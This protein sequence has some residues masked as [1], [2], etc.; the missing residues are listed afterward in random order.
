MKSLTCVSSYALHTVCIF[1]IALVTGCVDLYN[2]V[3]VRTHEAVGTTEVAILPPIYFEEH[4]RSLKPSFGLNSKTAF[5]Q[6]ITTGALTRDARFRGSALGL[7]A[8]NALSN[9]ETEVVEDIPTGPTVENILEGGSSSENT[10]NADGV[11]TILKSSESSTTTTTD[12]AGNIKTTTTTKPVELQQAQLMELSSVQRAAGLVPGSVFADES[13]EVDPMLRYLAATALYQE[14]QMLERYIDSVSFDGDYTPYVVRILIDNNPHARAMPYDTSVKIRFETPG[15]GGGLKGGVAESQRSTLLDASSSIY[16]VFAELRTNNKIRVSA[17]DKLN[18]AIT[19]AQSVIV[20]LKS[21]QFSHPNMKLDRLEKL[22]GEA[23]TKFPQV[24]ND[25]PATLKNDLLSLLFELQKEAKAV[26]DRIPTGQKPIVVPML[27]TDALEASMRSGATNQVRQIATNVN[28]LLDAVNVGV[29]WS[30]VDEFFQAVLGKDYNSLLKVSRD[31]HETNTLHVRLGAALSGTSGYAMLSRNHYVTTVVLVPKGAL[32]KGQLSAYVETEYRNAVNPTR[33]GEPLPKSYATVQNEAKPIGLEF[34][35]PTEAG[36]LTHPL[37]DDKPKLIATLI[38]DGKKT[39][40]VIPGNNLTSARWINA[41]LSIHRA[42]GSGQS[43]IGHIVASSNAVAENGTS[44]T[45]T[46][47]S[48]KALKLKDPKELYVFWAM[49]DESGEILKYQSELPTEQARDELESA[50]FESMQDL[51]DNGLELFQKGVLPEED[52]DAF[53]SEGDHLRRHIKDL[54]DRELLIFT[55]NTLQSALN[56][57]SFDQQVVQ[58]PY[59]NFKYRLRI[60]E[61]LTRTV[62]SFNVIYQYTKDEKKKAATTKLS[63]FKADANYVNLSDDA[64]TDQIKI[65][66]GGDP[67]AEGFRL[68]VSGAQVNEIVAES[69][70]AKTGKWVPVADAVGGEDKEGLYPVKKPCRLTLTLSK[71]NTDVPLSIGGA[72][73]DKVQANPLTVKVYAI[74]KK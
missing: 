17:Y 35:K 70:D 9:T 3:E 67:K 71:Y 12:N 47:P 44:V 63:F 40:C 14:V 15:G 24:H 7:T 56:K 45:F 18:R 58:Q 60:N 43:G 72:N 21:D 11:T 57:E 69:F 51:P 64:S 53:D 38:D 20:S 61:S 27:V 16:D 1:L 37:G 22:M 13:I 66:I 39:Q 65:K 31:T 48:I 25:L 32:E 19:S 4:R 55:E 52:E 42:D 30:S 46:F 54:S 59:E 62:Q 34:D 29:N 33:D 10:T 28:L 73:K 23:K 50:L 74:E 6:V 8:S 68:K 36:L 2:P 26:A 41:V 49:R 5:N